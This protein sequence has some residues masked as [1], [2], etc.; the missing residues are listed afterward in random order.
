MRRLSMLRPAARSSRSTIKEIGGIRVGDDRPGVSLCAGG[1]SQALRAGLDL[2][3]P[4]RRSCRS[5]S[6]SLRGNERVD[7]VLLLSHNGMDVDL[8][9]ASRVTGIDVILGGH[10]HDAVPQP[11]V[12]RQCRAARHW[13]SMAAR[14]ANSWRVLDLEV[15]RARSRTCAISLLP[16]YADLL[17]PDAGMQALIDRVIARRMP[18]ALAR[19][20]RPQASSSIGAAISMVRWIKLICDALRQELD[21]QIAL[22]PGFRWG[23]TMLAGQ[24]ITMEDVLS[25]TAI[26]YPEVYVQEMTGSQI[27]A[28]WRTS[29][30]TCSIPTRIISRAAT[31][32]A[33]A[34]WTTSCAPA[35]KHRA[36][37]FRT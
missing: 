33:S 1:A 2:R 7:A 31:W 12:D 17:K 23:A 16:V 35:R 32:C 5:S 19:S 25:E 15:G 26:T 14:T 22:S 11:V 10:T 4:R 24:P 8:K 37:E 30:T 20:S 34:A 29:A 21:A 13:S 27:K 3:H 36:A 18:R 9:L 6:I 28:S